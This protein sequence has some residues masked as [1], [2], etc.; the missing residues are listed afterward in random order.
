MKVSLIIIAV[1]VVVIVAA[2]LLAGGE[3]GPGRHGSDQK[4]ELQDGQGGHEVP[5]GT[6]G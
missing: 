4:Q 5:A 2:M 3:H 6:H 1:L